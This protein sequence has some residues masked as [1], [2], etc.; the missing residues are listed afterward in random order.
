MNAN[1]AQSQSSPVYYRIQNYCRFCCSDPIS[2]KMAEKHQKNVKELCYKDWLNKEVL[3]TGRILSENGRPEIIA[4]NGRFLAKTG[5]LESLVSF[6]CE[7]LYMYE[8]IVS[9][10]S[11]KK[12]SLYTNMNGAFIQG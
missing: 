3:K 2:V 11:N 9:P 5:G 4:E 12:L 6:H 1:L 8:S 7:E 10:V